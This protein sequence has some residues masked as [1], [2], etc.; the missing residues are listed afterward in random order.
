MAVAQPLN[1]EVDFA[2]NP[3]SE[4]AAWFFVIIL[5][6]ILTTIFEIKNHVKKILGTKKISFLKPDFYKPIDIKIKLITPPYK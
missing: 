5:E 2:R 3:I 1:F 6:F 4:S